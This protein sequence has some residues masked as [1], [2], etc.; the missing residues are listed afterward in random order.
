MGRMP[1]GMPWTSSARIAQPGEFRRELNLLEYLTE[2][3]DTSTQ[4]HLYG[5]M[6]LPESRRIAIA[7]A[8]ALEK[9]IS[10]AVE[11]YAHA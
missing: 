3:G 11:L 10:I 2:R 5:W 9:I 7:R 6:L 8:S 4:Q 1:G